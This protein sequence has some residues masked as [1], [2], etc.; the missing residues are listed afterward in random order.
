MHTW[1]ILL[2]RRSGFHAPIEF[3]FF[4]HLEIPPAVIPPMDYACVCHIW[5]VSD[6]ICIRFMLR[7]CSQYLDVINEFLYL[8]L[9][10]FIMESREERDNRR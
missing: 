1:K 10:Y 4:S 2:V 7:F 5:L 6:T 8:G 9:H 3:H